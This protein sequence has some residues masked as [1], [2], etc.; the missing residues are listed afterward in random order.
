MTNGE[1]LGEFNIRRGMFQGDYSSPLL[2]IIVM[3]LLSILL[4]REKLGYFFGFDCKLIN[5]LLFMDDLKLF[6]K[7]KGVGRSS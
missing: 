4:K 3:I 1:M 6:G 7:T 5:H 2:F